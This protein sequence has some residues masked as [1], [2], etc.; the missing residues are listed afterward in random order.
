MLNTVSD[1]ILM[2]EIANG[3]ELA[4][5]HVYQKF[6]NNL[7]HYFLKMTHQNQMKSEDLL[8]ELFIQIHQNAHKYN[9]EFKLSTWIYSIATNL[10]KNA[11]RNE[12]NRQR[13]LNEG[14]LPNATNATDHFVDFEQKQLANIIYNYIESVDS[15]GA[16]LLYLRY[17]EEFQLLEIAKIMNLPLGTVKSKIHY[18]MKKI[19]EKFNIKQY[20][21]NE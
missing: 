21:T 11:N 15:E 7:F 14:P 17:Q 20:G 16:Y 18:L 8:Q 6:G 19:S 9:P 5:R 3:S 10:V 12:A 4:F 1:K 2:S 13:I